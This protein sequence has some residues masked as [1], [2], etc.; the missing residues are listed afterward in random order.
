[1]RLITQIKNK[2]RHTIGHYEGFV[3]ILFVDT[4]IILH[5]D[6]SAVRDIV[7]KNAFYIRYQKGS[8]T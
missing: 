6:I 1:M 8:I 3:I 4:F 5:N 2:K 7:T